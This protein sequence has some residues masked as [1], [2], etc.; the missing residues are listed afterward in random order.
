M[1]WLR[2]SA[3]EPLPV[4]MSGIKLGDRLL[5][6]GCSDVALITALASKAGL[7]GRTCIVDADA[8]TAQRAAAAVEREGALVES[9]PAPYA[10]LPFE[11]AS[12]DVVVMR[13][14]LK[15]MDDEAR[16]QA[17]RAIHRVLRPGGRC[18]AIEGHQRRG[19]TQLLQG[20]SGPIDAAQVE[21]MLKGGGFRAV[22]TLAAREG[23]TFVEGVRPGTG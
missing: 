23:L 19:L 17:A 20:G 16:R 22:R 6:A 7:T 8:A 12:F 15:P 13:S 3:E 14:I 21:E 9:F 2:K 18:I 11:P 4:S 1:R 5:V 10:S